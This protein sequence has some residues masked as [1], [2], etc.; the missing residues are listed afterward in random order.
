[1]LRATPACN[2]AHLS[3]K[4]WSEHASKCASSHSLLPCFDIWTFKSGRRFT[5]PTVR[6]SESTNHWKKHSDSRLSQDFGLYLVTVLS[7]D[8]SS[9]L[10]FNFFLNIVGSLT[11]NFPLTIW[12]C[13]YATTVRLLDSTL[14]DSATIAWLYF[15]LTLFFLDSTLTWLYYYLTLVYH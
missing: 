8:S 9:L 4:K 2:F 3:F 6:S 10:F 12:L 5:E 7:H 11:S 1:M 14:L 13:Y 15:Y